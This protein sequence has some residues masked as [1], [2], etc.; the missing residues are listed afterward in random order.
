MLTDPQYNA[1][2]N[3]EVKATRVA[4]PSRKP[5][6][7]YVNTST[8]RHAIAPCNFWDY[9]QR[10]QSG[11]CNRCCKVKLF[12]L[13]AKRSRTWANRWRCS[14]ADISMSLV[15]YSANIRNCMVRPI[16]LVVMGR[17]CKTTTWRNL[18]CDSRGLNSWKMWP[19]AWPAQTPAFSPSDI[20]T[21]WNLW[22]DRKRDFLWVFF[23]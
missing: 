17:V 20:L 16:W 4:L 6:Y 19:L 18:V 15:S 5:P 21:L 14:L 22:L 12:W 1:W 9:H 23:F 10:D 11:S 3:C 2:E 7:R 8:I 13:K